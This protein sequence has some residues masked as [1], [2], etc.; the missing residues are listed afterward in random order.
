MRRL[1]RGFSLPELM[2]ALL[3]GAVG[4]SAALGAIGAVGARHREVDELARLQE[5]AAHALD[6][7]GISLQMAGSGGLVPLAALPWP[8]SLPAS[9]TGCGN[10][11]PR[12]PA[13]L[14][15]GAGAWPLDCP[16]A[17]GGHAE[18]THAVTVARASGRP[19]TLRAGRLQ[20]LSSR[21][22]A[23]PGG[24]VNGSLPAG[25]A[26]REGV[27]ELRDLVLETWY[28]AR[29]ADGEPAGGTWPALRVKELTEIAGRIAFRDSEIV[30]GIEDLRIEEGWHDSAAADAPLRFAPPG[31]RPEASALEAVRVHLLVRSRAPVVP[32]RA[33]RFAYA[34]VVR[35]TQD[36][37]LRLHASR[38]WHLRNAPRGGGAT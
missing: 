36:G 33:A 3:L 34:D 6:I 8:A 27:V 16:P 20:L 30:A 10:L 22:T 4:L 29:H 17:G 11:G 38:T 24:L 1:A 21:A 26:L 25:T 35:E 31:E 13:P 7:L 18:G 32:P 5:Q 37:F 9:A 28:V 19:A 2:I 14:R 15:V 12:A 23:V